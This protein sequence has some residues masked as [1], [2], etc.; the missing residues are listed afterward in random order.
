MDR[1]Q[2]AFDVG[3]GLSQKSKSMHLE[4]YPIVV[5]CCGR[6]SHEGQTYDASILLH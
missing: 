2:A 3:C 4:C 5:V 1:E 6:Y